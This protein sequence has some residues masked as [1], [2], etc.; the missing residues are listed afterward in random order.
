AAPFDDR[1]RVRLN[2]IK[3]REQW[4]P[5]AP[6]CLEADA[7][8]W[9]GCDHESPYMLFTYRA[10]TEAVAAV[11][12]VNGTA[13]LQTVRRSRN[14][15]LCELLAAFKAR[16]GYGVLCNTSLNFSGKGFINNLTD[17]DAYAVEHGLDGF[18]VEG[19]AY[20]L[21]SSERCRSYQQGGVSEIKET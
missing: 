9:F 1:T 16:T 14:A 2:E 7:A 21:R 13:R 17:L 18:V 5:I 20:L 15:Q 19:R 10:N 3:Q 12:H 6:V 4:R 8:R 11:T